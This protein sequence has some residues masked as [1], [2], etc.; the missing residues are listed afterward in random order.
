M[1]ANELVAV[2]FDPEYYVEFSLAQAHPVTVEAY[3][4]AVKC[5]TYTDHDVPSELGPVVRDVVRCSWRR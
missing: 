3:G 4:F 5:I 1:L 2:V